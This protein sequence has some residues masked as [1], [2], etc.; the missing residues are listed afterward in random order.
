MSDAESADT[1]TTQMEMNELH[2]LIDDLRKMAA[3]ETEGLRDYERFLDEAIRGSVCQSCDADLDRCN[4]DA[5]KDPTETY[6]SEAQIERAE[7]ELE[8]AKE[9][10]RMIHCE[11]DGW[12]FD[13]VRHMLKSGATLE[14]INTYCVSE[15][16]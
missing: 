2:K 6:K 1:D 15:D 14:E 13:V 3:T 10:V 4:C 16:A 9:R 11:I 8:K 12:R 5:P 7:K